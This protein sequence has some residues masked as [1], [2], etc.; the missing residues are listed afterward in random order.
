MAAYEKIVPGAKV[1][2]D[3]GKSPSDS[4]RD[5]PLKTPSFMVAVTP[6]DPFTVM[7]LVATV[8]SEPNGF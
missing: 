5:F 7:L 6:D 1:S 8:P 3:A 2:V 4:D